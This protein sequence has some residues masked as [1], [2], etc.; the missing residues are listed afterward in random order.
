MI[1]GCQFEL[2]AAIKVT[3]EAHVV[4]VL[5]DAGHRGMHIIPLAEK[6]KMNPGYLRK[7]KSPTSTVRG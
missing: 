7:R 2:S 3:T 6:V 1:P 4:E 5:R